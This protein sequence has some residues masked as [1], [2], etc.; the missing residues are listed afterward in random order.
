MRSLGV[1]ASEREGGQAD[2]DADGHRAA[3]GGLEDLRREGVEQALCRAPRGS[4]VRV[5]EDDHELIAAVAGGDVAGPQR[6]ADAL[7]RP[8]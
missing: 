3:L 7:G 6:R 4:H 1:R 5:R 8:A 2:G